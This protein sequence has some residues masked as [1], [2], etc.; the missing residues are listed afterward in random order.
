MGVMWMHRKFRKCAGPVPVPNERRAERGYSL[1]EVL[2]VLSIIAL[3]AT[4]AG[5][6][7]FAQLDRSKATSA[8]IQ[9][10]SL[11]SALETM[12]LD[13]GRYP[14]D[15]EGLSLLVVAPP[16]ADV[17]SLEWRGPYLDSVVP[18]DP[19]GS[20]Y[21]YEAPRGGEGRPRLVS[22]GADGKPGGEGVAKDVAFPAESA[23]AE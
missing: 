3:I 23:V 16:P 12:R 15:E 8:R 6:R 19:W 20:A 1:L 9:I 2:V 22:Y 7:I 11:S 13:I 18:M 14:S 4:F 10:Q 5:P 21:L 17:E